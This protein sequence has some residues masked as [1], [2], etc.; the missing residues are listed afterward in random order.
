MGTLAKSKRL[1]SK[2]GISDSDSRAKLARARYV[3]RVKAW[4]QFD[5]ALTSISFTAQHHLLGPRR[6]HIAI[7]RHVPYHDSGHADHTLDVYQPVGRPGPWPV[8]MYV[9]G[10]GF[11]ACSKETHWMMAQTYA[12][13]GFLVFT[14]NYRLAPESPFPAA[15]ADTCAAY[16]WVLDNAERYGGDLSQVVVAGESAGANLVTALSV[17]ATYER[18]EPWASEVFQ[19]GR[20]PDVTIAAC[21]L[22]QVSDIA[23]LWRRRR[24]PT[25]VCRILAE[26]G[27]SY[28]KG[29]THADPEQIAL[30]DPLRILEREAPVRPLPAFFVPC[31]TRD[32]LLDD[33]RRLARALAAHNTPVQARFYKREIHAFHLTIVSPNARTCWRDTLSFLDE[34][35]SIPAERLTCAVA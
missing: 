35:L 31:G 8:L 23:R 5:R 21:G 2:L 27:N 22:F 20:V 30:A 29:W 33:S 26:V 1:R 14:I 19:R 16:N 15:I 10:G 17:A 3:D 7:E 9:H 28:L 32:P 11:A 12:R 4:R 34:H 13:K 18:P 6:R 25:Y 24:M